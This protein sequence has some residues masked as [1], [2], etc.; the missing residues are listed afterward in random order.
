MQIEPDAEIVQPDFGSQAS[1]KA[2][3]AREDS[4]APGERYSRACR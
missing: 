3:E 1:L 2:R 4:D